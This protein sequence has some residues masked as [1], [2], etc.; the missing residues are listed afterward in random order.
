LDTFGTGADQVV[1]VDDQPRNVTGAEDMGI[2]S[3]AFDVSDPEGSFRQ[4]ARLL[5]IQDIFENEL[6]R[7]PDRDPVIKISSG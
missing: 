7:K 5:A 3:V 6:A 4:A 1:F 2:S